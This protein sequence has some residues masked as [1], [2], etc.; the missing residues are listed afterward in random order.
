M[1][2]SARRASRPGQLDSSTNSS[3]AGDFAARMDVGDARRERVGLRHAQRAA[4]RLHLAIDVR[5]GD[6]VEVDQ[7]QRADAAARQGLGRPRADAAEAD[8]GDVGGANARVAAIAVQAAQAAEAPLEVGL[9]VAQGDDGNAGRRRR[10]RSAASLSR[11]ACAASDFGYALSRSSIVLRRGLGVLELGL[12]VGDG[13][14]RLGRARAVGGARDQAAEGRDR[15]LVVAPRVLRVAE[16]EQRRLAI[17]AVRKALQQA[18]EAGRGAVE[19]AAPKAREGLVV[20][21][22]FLGVDAELLV[23]DGHLLRLDLADALVD[24]LLQVGLL[25]LQLGDDAG[26]LFHLAAHASRCRR[27]ASRC[28]RSARAGCA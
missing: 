26:E 18:A 5:L 22:L 1:T 4:Q 7:R 14:H 8:D 10:H 3:T 17:A 15:L 9:V 28:C 27:A 12:A 2:T 24:A 23:V 21:A 13:E 16:P 20:A 11:P 25:P 6:V 19:L